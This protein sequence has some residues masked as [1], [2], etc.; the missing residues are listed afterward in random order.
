MVASHVDQLLR[1]ERHVSF[2][3]WFVSLHMPRS[4]AYIKW[5]SSVT[6][7][8]SKILFP[9]TPRLEPHLEVSL[10]I[11]SFRLDPGILF[12]LV[13]RFLVF[14]KMSKIVVLSSSDSTKKAINEYYDSTSDNSSDNSS[15]S[16]EGSSSDEGYTFS[17]PGL[18]LEVVPGLSSWRLVQCTSV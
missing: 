5:N 10:S 15:H 4:A 11:V 16:N 1:G 18:P 7:Y 14:Q 13:F 6:L 3:D 17:V 12:F 9:D 8:I 2:L